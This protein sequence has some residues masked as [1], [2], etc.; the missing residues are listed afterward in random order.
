LKAGIIPH[1]LVVAV[2]DVGSSYVY[3]ASH[4]DG[5]SANPAAPPMGQRFYL[6]YS[7]AEIAA[8]AV[9]PWKKAILTALAHYGFYVG[10]SG[11]ETLSF[12]WEG[13]LMYTPFGAGEPFAE[14]GHEQGVPGSGGSYTFNLS[15]GVDW[16]RLRAVAPPAP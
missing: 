2:K 15:Q 12:L 16:T 3:P 9:L 14:I 5:N 8:L 7:D 6:A 4:T 10:D 13:S 11:N 1:A